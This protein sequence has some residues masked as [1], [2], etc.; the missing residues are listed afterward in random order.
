MRVQLSS[1]FL[2]LSMDLSSLAGSD[3][4][5]KAASLSLD[6]AIASG[7]RQNGPIET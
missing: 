5:I 2:S 6:I 7:S 1:P 4:D 3:G